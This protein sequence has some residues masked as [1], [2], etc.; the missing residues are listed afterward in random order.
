MTAESSSSLVVEA[1][2]D[3]TYHDVS[4]HTKAADPSDSGEDTMDANMSVASSN[5]VPSNDNDD[6]NGSIFTRIFENTSTT[7]TN[8]A[9]G[10]HDDDTKKTNDIVLARPTWSSCGSI[11]DNESIVSNFVNSS[12]LLIKDTSDATRTKM[13]ALSSPTWLTSDDEYGGKDEFQQT[14]Q[15][16]QQHQQESSSN[17][18]TGIWLTIVALS[19]FSILGNSLRMFIEGMLG[20]ACA[21]QAPAWLSSVSERLNFCVTSS[22]TALFYDLPV[23]MIG[24]FIMGMFQPCQDIGLKSSVPIAFLKTNHWFQSSQVIHIAIRTGFCGSLTTFASWNTSMLQLLSK[25]EIVTALVGYIIGAELAMSS[26]KAGQQ[27]SVWIHRHLNPDL[28]HAEDL[29]SSLEPS[30]INKSVMQKVYQ[31]NQ[32]MPDFE[33]RYL[34]GLVSEQEAEQAKEKIA[35]LDALDQW[36]KTTQDH[37]HHRRTSS[38][39][40]TAFLTMQEIEHKIIVEH[41]NPSEYVLEA[42][43]EYGWDVDALKAWAEQVIVNSDH[44]QLQQRQDDANEIYNVE[45]GSAGRNIHLKKESSP[46][47][48]PSENNLNTMRFLLFHALLAFGLLIFF[49]CLSFFGTDTSF[50]QSSLI[51]SLVSPFGTILRWYLSRLNGKLK[52]RWNWF[53]VGTFIANISASIISALVVGLSIRN[54]SLFQPQQHE[55]SVSRILNALRIG[56]TGCLSTVSTLVTEYDK[57]NKS[58]PHHA[59][60]FYYMASSFITA[61]LLGIIIYAPLVI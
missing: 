28:A 5:W 3:A 20:S 17:A 36:K 18:Y 25:G 47:C 49:G 11:D 53:P 33:R 1:S 59:K 8:T 26:L 51:S 45:D 14:R 34:D 54:E 61:C 10:S 40:Q 48:L 60:P 42:A 16:Q 7:P 46:S 23:N 2:D 35:A 57:I 19:I 6:D 15:Q 22:Q 37:R 29:I 31:K 55:W 13:N 44:S 50:Y 21:H 52:G 30:P 38:F 41:E 4:E 56:F 12:S 27:I 58:F 9:G 43:R 32:S 24:S 39:S